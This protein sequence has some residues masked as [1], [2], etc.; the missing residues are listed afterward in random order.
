[1]KRLCCAIVGCGGIAQRHGQVLQGL[2]VAQLLAC[3]DILPERAQAL[4]EKYCEPSARAYPSLEEL[5]DQEEI[6]VLHICTPHYL[7]V[8]MAQAAASRGVHV[9][10]EKPPVIDLGQWEALQAL[11]GQVRVGVCFQNRYNP[12]VA[13]CRKLLA[14]GKP[15]KILG[16]RAFVTWHREAPYYVESGWRGFLYTEGGGVLINQAVHTL[17][18]LTQFLGHGRVLGASLANRH[19]QR[20]IEVEDTLEATLDFSGVRALFYA[21]TAYC[22]D[23]PVLVELACE[24]GVLRIE[25]EEVTVHWEDGS[26][27]R[28]DFAQEERIDGKDYWGNS[29]RRC[30]EAFYHSVLSGEPFPNDIPGVADTAEL[31]LE[32]YAAARKDCTPRS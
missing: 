5:L 27:Y 32:V 1:M 24:H 9:F 30:I 21:T 26:L 22:Q 29:H 13:F 15:G 12:S 6:D 4:R 14:E 10:M 31:M 18:L 16:A 11:Q 7:H 19:L 17:D 20:L 25:G 8:P 3:A 23:A 2:E 28:K